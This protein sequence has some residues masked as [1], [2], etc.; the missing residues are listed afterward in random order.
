MQ[1]SQSSSRI[2]FRAFDK[3]N[4]QSWCQRWPNTKGN[5]KKKQEEEEHQKQEE[6]DHQKKEEEEEEEKKE[7]SKKT[8][9]EAF[10][11]LAWSS[12]TGLNGKGG[13]R[14]SSLSMFC[15]SPPLFPMRQQKL[16]Q[17]K[18]E[19]HGRMSAQ[20]RAALKSVPLTFPT[21]QTIVCYRGI[22]IENE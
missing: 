16:E 20:R 2:R 10:I 9:S 11:L 1:K 7:K 8:S 19:Q 5:S 17:Q 21:A 15:P 18:L 6:E 3:K 4:S 13:G 14:G 12:K 22:F